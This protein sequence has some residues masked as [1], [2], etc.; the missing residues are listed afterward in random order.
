MSAITNFLNQDGLNTLW[1]KIKTYISNNTV[2]KETGKGLSTNDFTAAYKSLLDSIDSTVG[3]TSHLV[4][5]SAVNKAISDL[6]TQIGNLKTF[7]IKV[8]TE[9]PTSGQESNVIY[10]IKHVKSSTDTSS[11]HTGATNIRPG[12]ADI[13]DEYLW[14]AGDGKFEKIGNTDIDLSAYAKTQI[15]DVFDISAYHATGGTLATYD[16]LE[17]ALGT[18]GKNIPQS[19]RK[20]GMSVKFVQTSDHKYIQ[21]RCMAQNF[22]TDV[23]KWQGVD[24]E[25][26][27]GSNNLVE[28]GG[29]DKAINQVDEKNFVEY[30]DNSI[31]TNK[32]VT[33]NGGSVTAAPFT[34]NISIP[35][36]NK[37]YVTIKKVKGTGV[38]SRLYFGQQNVSCVFDG[39]G[40]FS[41]VFTSS[42]DTAVAVK[43]HQTASGETTTYQI[44]SIKYVHVSDIINEKAD[45]SELRKILLYDQTDE[46]KKNITDAVYNKTISATTAPNLF[47]LID[48][49]PD[50]DLYL[51][52]TL[53][54]G[55]DNT[56]DITVYFRPNGQLSS[57]FPLTAT[58]VDSTHRNITVPASRLSSYD[59]VSAVLSLRAGT[60]NFS[61]S[62]KYGLL[63]DVIEKK[64][65]E[66][67]LSIRGIREEIGYD[68]KE[69]IV[70]P[71]SIFNKT[72]AI[73]T[74]PDLL[75]YIDVIDGADMTIDLTLLSGNDNTKTIN[76]YIQ[77]VGA[78]QFAVT[79]V[80][81]GENHRSVKVPASSFSGFSKFK[82]VLYIHA[83]TYNFKVDV[84]YG[85]VANG[86]DDI[87]KRTTNL[88]NVSLEFAKRILRSNNV[89]YL[90]RNIITISADE[91]DECDYNGAQSIYNAL[92]SINDASPTNR[93]CILVKRG[94]YKI[95][96]SSEFHSYPGN[97]YV[98][99]Y[100][101]DC[102][103]II[104][105]DPRSCVFEASISEELTYEQRTAY[106][107]LF[108][109]GRA[110][111]KNISIIAFDLRYAIHR[112]RGSNYLRC[113]NVISKT[114]NR[115]YQRSRNVLGMGTHNGEVTEIIGGESF[116][117]DGIP[118]SIH[119]NVNFNYPS[120]YKIE[121]H[122]LNAPSNP[123]LSALKMDEAGSGVRNSVTLIGC[124][125]GTNKRVRWSADI[126]N[127]DYG[128]KGAIVNC[129]N[130]SLYGFGNSRFWF[131]N[132]GGPRG[133]KILADELVLFTGG[134]A[135]GIALNP[136]N[137]NTIVPDEEYN[138]DGFIYKIPMGTIQAYAIGLTPTTFWPSVLGDCR[139][140]NKTLTLEIGEQ[141][142]TVTFSE[143]YSSM[144]VTD[145]VTSV[146]GSINTVIGV[147][148]SA[149]TYSYTKDYYA[150]CTDVCSIVANNS[151][152]EVI[153]KGM[154]VVLEENGV[155]KASE[156]EIPYAIALDDFGPRADYVLNGKT[157]L[158]GFGRIAR[159]C[160]LPLSTNSLVYT[161]SAGYSG[162]IPKLSNGD[163]LK[164]STNGYLVQDENGNINVIK[165]N[166][167]VLIEIP[168]M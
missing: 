52:F 33:L 70:L 154:A 150:E 99:F 30:V 166:G 143:D 95:T 107:T 142:Y 19:L 156:G 138:E 112:D 32:Q 73:T 64:A 132:I 59:T 101:K 126:Y 158:K 152:T 7:N 117:D 65:N 104:G 110:L 34:K 2:A 42:S 46:I 5:N 9:L 68:R 125:F 23:T 8:V 43:M 57:Q 97:Y 71:N 48:V 167:T 100:T 60:Y 26:T 14:V 69:N 86:L 63:D 49:F 61:I 84:F 121:N 21:T 164:V 37:L 6:R 27:D 122:R 22:T 51:D 135:A 148:G 161:G 18:N 93:Y 102:V 11:A 145:C 151:T 133:L 74:A 120:S 89:K 140:V 72:T 137:C 159:N 130:F 66:S 36:G 41:H 29:V 139:T 67:D 17:D 45:K 80:D 10:L 168:N 106:Q 131:D 108:T 38:N 16:N 105:E 114:F 58:S 44:E 155:R 24:D 81:D 90:Y 129:A 75:D 113:E 128:Q 163:K 25:P 136:I 111:L 124:N 39:S 115:K 146:I 153:L 162:V 20:G 165:N 127:A 3:D 35:S 50:R 1:S 119:T 157:M 12:A 98:Y 53:L 141:S 82:A 123:N 134:T 116:S 87:S 149:E 40:Y 92:E 62:M 15:G 77:P 96:S 91:N 13:Y 4:K 54:S 76:V 79:P 55:N 83:G 88:E 144:N 47:G 147:N 109:G 56:K 31:I 118:I 85:N 94:I 160:F 28:S 78:T 103:D